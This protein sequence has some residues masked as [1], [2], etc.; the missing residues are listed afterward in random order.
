[1][2]AWDAD[3]TGLPAIGG[4]ELRSDNADITA[5][6]LAGRHACVAGGNLNDRTA[7]LAGGLDCNR[8]RTDFSWRHS[9]HVDAHRARRVPAVAARI[10]LAECHFRCPDRDRFIYHRVRPRVF[11]VVAPRRYYALV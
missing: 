1:M 5:E 9:G 10:D 7:T 8:A 11:R 6:Q 3:P 4:Q 2:I